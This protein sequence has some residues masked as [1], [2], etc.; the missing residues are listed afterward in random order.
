M[1]CSLGHVPI[2]PNF[3]QSL[4]VGLSNIQRSSV[5]CDLGVILDSKLTIK[6]HFTKISATCFH[7]MSRLSQIRRPVGQ[8][9]TEQLVVAL[10]MSRLDYCNSLLVGL[11][12]PHW[13]HYTACPECSCSTGVWPRWLRPRHTHQA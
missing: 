13:S 2:S 3:N 5:V 4:Q 6:Q 8:E 9:V 12:S 10:K 1:I 11:P 7:H